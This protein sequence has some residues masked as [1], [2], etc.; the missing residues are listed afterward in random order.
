MNEISGQNYDVRDKV[1]NVENYITRNFVVY[2]VLI[3]LIMRLIQNY[4]EIF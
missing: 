4:Q 1:R 3:I 2:V